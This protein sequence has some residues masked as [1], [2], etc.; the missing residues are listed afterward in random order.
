MEIL[1]HVN[2]DENVQDLS[3]NE[4]DGS[5]KGE[6]E[7]V[8]G[9][10]GKAIHIVN[11]NG[12]TSQVA[13]QYV[14][15]GKNIRFNN[16]DFAISFWYKSD[17]GVSAGGALI[18]NKNF[19][20]GSNPGLN[21]GN[22]DTGLRVNFTPENSG[23]YDVY[24]F[25]P[26]DGV[27]H[28]VAINFD[29]DGTIDTYVDNQF[30]QSTNIADD[31]DKSIDVANFVVGADGYFKNGLNDAYIDELKVYSKL[32]SEQEIAD[33]YNL[34]NDEILY[35]NFNEENA[36][37]ISGNENHGQAF[38]VTY[39]EGIDGKAAHIV[40]T[41][42]STSAK[43][44]QYIDFGNDIK[45]TDQDFALSFWYKSDNGVSN[46]G[47]LISNKDFD[48]GS[49]KGFN[50][51]NFDTGLRV[52]FTPENSE[53]YDVYNFAPID[54]IWHY[55][56]VNFDRDGYIETFVDNKVMGR[57][58]ISNEIN[59]SIDV[60]NFVVGADG[61]FKNG[62]NDAYV[63]ELNVFSRLMDVEEIESQYNTTYLQYVVNE[64]DKFYQEALKNI[65]YDKAKLA[66]LYNSIENARTAIKNED[67][68]KIDELVN[69]INIKLAAVKEGIEGV[70]EG[71][72]LY[73]SFD[74]ENVKDES[75]RENHG[76]SV[77]DVTYENGVIGKALHI[78][79]ENG[80]TMET[81]KQ[82]VNFGQPD[83]LKFKTE[84]FAISFWYKT[85][86][87]GGKEAAIISNKDWSTGSN[88][89]INIGN[90]GNSIRVNYT[91][92]GCNR[93]DIYG[94]S[95]NDDNWHYI[96]V[97]FDRDKEVSAYIDGNLEKTMD[98]KDTYGKTIDATD[99][100]IGADGNKT[101]GINDAYI[102][103]V[104]IMKR[105]FSSEEIDT[106]YLPYRFQ[107]TEMPI[108][109]FQVLS[110][111]HIDGS[112]DNN[113]SRQNLID[114]L[115]D[116]SVLDPTSSAVMFPGDITDSGSEA[117]YESFYDII[118]K[119]NF[120]KSIIA[121]GNH[122]VRW[123]CSSDDR[124]EPGANVPTCK[125]GTSPFKER[126]LKYNTPYMDGTTDELYFD[127]WIN[128]YHFI[129]L[130]TEKDLKDNAYL[131]N[132]QLNWLKDVIKEDA[133][134]DKPIF[135][136]IHQTFTNTADHESLDLIGEQEEALKEILKDYP[137]SIIF[138]GH[139]HNGIDL[140]KVYQEEYGYVV[141]VPAFKYQSYGDSRAQIGYQ[142]NVFEDR[143]EI[144]PRDYKNDLWL[145][146][147]KTDILFDKEIDKTTLQTLYDECLTL[148]ESEYTS[149]SWSSFKTAMDEAKA[150]IDKQDATQEEVDLAYNELQTA[151]DA[152]VKVV[153]SD[154]TALKIAVDLANAITD[155]D[156]ANVV[157][158]V[159]DEFKA[160]RDK[161][162]EVYNNASATQEE[163]NNAF[164]RLA[165]AMQKLEFFKGDKT[166]LKAFIDKVSDLDSFKYT[167]STWSAF[168]KE[169]NE[170]NVVYN[171]VNA[172]QEEVNTTYS[173][174]VKAFLNLRLIPDKSLLEDLIN[175]AEGLDSANYTKASF[176]G[177][178]R[179]LNEAKV[180]FENPNATQVEVD[181]AKATLEKAIA[182]LQ[183]NPSTPSNVDNT[184]STPV[185]NGDTTTSVKT[186]DESLVGMFATITLLSVTGYA[187]LRRK[188]N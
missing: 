147:Y 176:D 30:I 70:V 50:I 152:L 53:R 78:Q 124:N 56:V 90:F 75:G 72:V 174:L 95:A 112:D 8:D 12:S 2:F 79:N 186:G 38:N 168:D 146:E 34:N 182:G 16:N 28:Y 187:V 67:Y 77:G 39:S 21:I 96:V 177:L 123:L 81:A 33:N 144:R 165:N 103:E 142:V 138:T 136:Q 169:L 166:A 150:I 89:G 130:N 125:Y 71:Q 129:T 140:A 92:Q 87:G 149:E 121:L 113:K 91:G 148:K 106:Y 54:G 13:N 47:A 133:H 153:D 119:Y 159:A 126:Y 84:D 63:D 171:N 117:Q 183:A 181:N 162:N 31:F 102:D 25:A 65:K 184:V 45:F 175:Q 188:E 107:I 27:W 160:A 17:N 98:I 128:D 11:S 131:S 179:A 155:E 185:N 132:E 94:L 43:A 9:I 49:N 7:Y 55:V 4:N 15:F 41:N 86:D 163:V 19:D 143:V 151:K 14:D 73:L 99:F 167:E 29:R 173:E 6:V 85:V 5:V 114:A 3:G 82:Y 51:G 40:N 58:D 66:N 20:S 46:G 111:V 22:F 135:I 80:S 172:M 100:V 23:R 1:L 145:D 64:A 52:N 116:I 59:K 108:M 137:Q 178:T 26:I 69:D 61:Y 97:N 139:V 156:L 24:N 48:S 110:D 35:L 158:A 122:D 68:S 118:E 42:G 76:I 115:E 127:T 32:M 180:V 36:N 83:D 157:Q 134:K 170:A 109:S 44:E 161:A 101:Q 164:D 18:S 104:R 154:K 37:D 141:D 93:D 60:S 88:V 57:T 120:T 62:L 74:N 105:L 10:K